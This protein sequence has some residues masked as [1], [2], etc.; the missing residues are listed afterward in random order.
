M[1]KLRVVLDG[2]P[3]CSSRIGRAEDRTW[4]WIGEKADLGMGTVVGY[5]VAWG[6][7]HL[8]LFSQ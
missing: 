2:G 8:L 6:F 5:K 1:W 4:I 7:H 3:G